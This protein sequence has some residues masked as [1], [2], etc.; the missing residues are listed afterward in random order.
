MQERVKMP[1]YCRDCVFRGSVFAWNTCDYAFLTGR[2]R[3]A[4]PAGA[5]CSYKAKGAGGK[6]DKPVHS[7]KMERSRVKESAKNSKSKKNRPDLGRCGSDKTKS[8]RE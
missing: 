8:G 4:Q 1:V 5:G 3:K 6:A 7:N 2:T